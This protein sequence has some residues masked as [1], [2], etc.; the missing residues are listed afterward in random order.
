MIFT[1]GVLVPWAMKLEHCSQYLTLN[2]WSRGK[3]VSFVSL[4]S[5]CSPCPGP[6]ETSK[7][8]GNKTN[9]FPK[10]SVILNV[11][12]YITNVIVIIKHFLF[13]IYCQIK[14]PF[15]ALSR[16]RSLLV[17]LLMVNNMIF[18]VAP[19]NMKSCW[20]AHDHV[21]SNQRMKN[22][23]FDI[24][25]ITLANNQQPINGPV[26]FDVHSCKSSGYCPVSLI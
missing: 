4:K 2:D 9:W 23:N 26:L 16:S 3:P 5:R 22:S 12:C 13:N 6:G 20:R 24:C 15:C 17:L 14:C 10:G 7:L 25:Y 21:S 19:E 18:P 1:L 11:F 8:S